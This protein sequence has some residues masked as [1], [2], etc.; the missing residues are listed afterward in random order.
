MSA[1][2]EIFR[3]KDGQ[4]YFR[5]KAG[6]GEKILASEGYTTKANCQNGIDSVKANASNDARYKKL[7]ATNGQH[8]FTLTASN[9]QV[10]GRSETYTSTQGRDAGIASVKANGP[11]A[12]VVDL[13]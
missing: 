3:G 10:I 2:Y 1:T 11:G 8:Y 4:F 5:L 13:S 6:N 12:T 7:T 9:G